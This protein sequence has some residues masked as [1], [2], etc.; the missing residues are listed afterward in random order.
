MDTIGLD[1]HKRES[2]L[3]ILTTDGELTERRIATMRAR[4][5]EVLG[6]RS[7]ARILLEA[8]TESEWVAR[9]LESLGHGSL[10]PTRSDQPNPRF[11]IE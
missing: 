5:T 3:C 8:S 10:S 6:G 9:H 2:Q 11:Q 7:R 4:F 1:L